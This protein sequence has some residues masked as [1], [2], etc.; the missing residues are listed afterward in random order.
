MLPNDSNTESNSSEVSRWR[1]SFVRAVVEAMMLKDGE[2]LTKIADRVPSP[3]PS[4]L[5]KIHTKPTYIKIEIEY[6]KK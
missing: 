3:L 1:L 4:L 5:S 6:F 2:V